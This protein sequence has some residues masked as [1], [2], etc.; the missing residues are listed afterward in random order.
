VG[1]LW[2]EIG[3]LQFDFLVA[4]GLEP[5]HVFL[6]IACGSLRGGLHFIPYLDPG[7]YLGIDREK[8]LID[9][10][11]AVE[12]DPVVVA[13]KRPEFVVSSSFE[14]NRFS[15]VPQMSL[16]Q[17]LFTHLDRPDIALC[18]ANL[19]A[20]VA[21]GHQLF[22]TFFEASVTEAPGASHSWKAFRYPPDVLLALGE[23]HGWKPVY[24]GDWQ[25]PRDQKMMQFT[26][27]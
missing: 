20:F 17:S 13:T 19:R 21:E 4:R 16:A 23:R 14:F 1:G 6:D 3:K 18:L 24:I 27:A 12:V 22:A 5:S 26:A 9:R 25:H 8:R 2:D 11:L 15:K 7:H 10:G